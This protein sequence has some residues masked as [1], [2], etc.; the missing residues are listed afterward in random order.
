MAYVPKP[1]QYLL[2]IDDLCP[3]VNQR[4]WERIYE[5]VQEFGIRPILAVIPA[6]EDRDLKVSP[7]DPEFWDRMRTMQDSGATIA[8]HGYR[9]WCAGEGEGLIHLHRKTEF[10]GVDQ[11]LQRVWIADGLSILRG[12]GL[13]PKLWVA[14]KHSFDYNTL[15]ALR[16]EGIRYLSDGLARIPF[17]R[18]GVTWIPQQL[19]SPAERS[20]GLWT[21]C[22][23]P[24]KTRR[25][26]FEELRLFV[27]QNAAQITSFDRVVAEFESH[28]LGRM[29]RFHELVATGRLYLHRRLRAK[30]HSA[31][32]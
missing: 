7:P 19:W 10:A 27:E 18:G 16:K 11:P 9:H 24:N 14:P 4:R 28:H 12:H 25:Q 1:A 17:R 2:R 15:S 20:R 29:E 6:N 26:K 30:G 3:T 23:H 21:L 5:L 13:E 31:A 22:V 8:L 32:E